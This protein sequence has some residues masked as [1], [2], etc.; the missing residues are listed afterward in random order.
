MEQSNS[1]DTISNRIVSKICASTRSSNEAYQTCSQD[2]LST[3]TAI[4]HQ[5]SR[6]WFTLLPPH[7]AHLS[8]KRFRL[9]KPCGLFLPTKHLLETKVWSLL[10]SWKVVHV[11]TKPACL[12]Q[13]LVFSK[14]QIYSLK[15]SFCFFRPKFCP[16]QFHKQCWLRF[17]YIFFFLRSVHLTV[18]IAPRVLLPAVQT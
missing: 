7:R 12:L 13:N 3:L 14:K 10:V 2:K 9:W 1:S 15:D 16:W 17:V 8:G 18:R 11:L 5:F 4:P 6:S